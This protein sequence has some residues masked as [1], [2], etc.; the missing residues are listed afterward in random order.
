MMLSLFRLFVVP[1]HELNEHRDHDRERDE[2][3][4]PREKA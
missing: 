3:D 4:K 1:W 2:S